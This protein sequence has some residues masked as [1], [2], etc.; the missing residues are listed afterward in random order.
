M[1][2]KYGT[3]TPSGTIFAKVEEGLK[4]V[5]DWAARQF[6]IG[7]DVASQKV[8]EAEDHLASARAE[9]AATAKAKANEI[10]NEL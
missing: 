1:Y 10:K 8:Q 5:Y 4:G 2:F 3:S 7:A 6:N 9:A